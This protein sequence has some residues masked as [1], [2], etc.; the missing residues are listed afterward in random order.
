VSAPFHGP[1]TAAAAAA[2]AAAAAT[3]LIGE[4]AAGSDQQQHGLRLC[5]FSSSLPKAVDM[6]AALQ[7]QYLT[8]VELSPVML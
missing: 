6:L 4:T 5:S 7:V 1:A 8:R 2:V 3:T